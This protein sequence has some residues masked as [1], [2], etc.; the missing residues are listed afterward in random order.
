MMANPNPGGN[1]Y[2]REGASRHE[3][4]NKVISD[5]N[6]D[7]TSPPENTDCIALSTLDEVDPD[8]IWTQQD[9]ET[10]RDAIDE[11]CPFSWAEDLT[12]WHD[13]IITEIDTALGRDLGGWGD[14]G[15]CCI[16]ED[17]IPACSDCGET[18]DSSADTIVAE[19]CLVWPMASCATDWIGWS[20]AKDA[21]LDYWTIVKP[22]NQA[23]SNFS[24]YH[25]NYCYAVGEVEELEAELAV[26]EAIRDAACSQDPPDPPAC[27]AAQAAVDAKQAELA[28]KIAERDGY[29]S[30][31]NTA[32]TSA[33]TY[34]NAQAAIILALSHPE[35]ENMW[36]L[37]T[38]TSHPWTDQGCEFEHGYKGVVRCRWRWTL[39]YSVDGG[40]WQNRWRGFYTPNGVPYA[41]YLSNMPPFQP[42]HVMV[43]CWSVPP[44]GSCNNPD[45]DCWEANNEPWT[46]S[47]LWQA[48][49]Y[50]DESTCF[51]FDP[52]TGYPC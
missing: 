10:V 35:Q 29:Q 8:H 39:R 32:A 40:A 17:C 4:W 41:T 27:A 51:A 22:L 19:G 2:E 50:S 6:T 28:A 37:V 44:S 52:L 15:E 16:D 20:D 45:T 48:H 1:V 12:Y 23:V 33:D 3:A 5:V 18:D 25:A 46:N 30:Q 38:A 14:E 36:S 42:Y 26:L 9:V 21:A 49:A 31:M 47:C 11:M 43:C 24:Y 34:A 7:R 13:D